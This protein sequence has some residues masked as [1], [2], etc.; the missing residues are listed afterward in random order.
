MKVMTG[1][2]KR[3]CINMPP[4]HG[5]SE[6]VTIR[7]PAYFMENFQNKNI[8]VAGYNQ[9][10]SRRFSRR[11]RQIVDDTI[12]LDEK[13]QSVEE[14]QTVNNNYYYAASTSNPR[15]G[16]GFHLIILDDLVK[17]REEANSKTHKERVK[18]FYRED[19]YSRLEPDGAIIIC[20]TRW[21]EDDIIAEAIGT[22]PEQWTV[23]SLPALCE[24]PE[25]DVL[26][27]ELD[28]A[29]W[30]ER[31]T[32]EKL[33]NIKKVMGEFGFAALYQQRPVPK[34]GG[35]F[36][37][38]RLE[39]DTPPKMIRK[40]RAWDL[41]ASSGKGDYTVGVLMGVDEN[42][43]YWILDL[44]RDRVSTDVRDKQMIQIASIDGIETRIRLA[45]DP[46][47]AGKSMKDYFIKF[48]AGYT[49]IAKPV[50]GNKEVRAEPFAIQVNEG[51]VRLARGSWNREFLNELGNFPY[52]AYDDI[53]DACSDAF[54]EISKV[55]M[56]RF[57]AV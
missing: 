12:G 32:T 20:N 42:Q 23:I 5:K 27:R 16:I 39:I 9:S 7:F 6:N 47:S 10:I 15:T 36:K 38:D 45:Q 48:L 19:C 43:N 34:E 18:D 22:E 53:I 25:K 35:L 17:N 56:K 37:T 4:R 21:S 46:G 49:V 26:N 14:W 57:F 50:S 2:I 41:A 55:R 52:G 40:V 11:T 8:M 13:N 33:L 28:E 30:P 24:D 31:Y 29:L 3:L 44:Y 1:E 54:E 51:N